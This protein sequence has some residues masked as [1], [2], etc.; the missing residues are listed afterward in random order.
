M[1]LDT[2]K[3][4]QELLERFEIKG[5]N[6]PYW[7]ADIVRD[8]GLNNHVV[9][10]LCTEMNNEGFVSKTNQEASLTPEGHVF[11]H[12]G[13]YERHLVENIPTTQSVTTTPNKKD[14]TH[15]PIWYASTIFKYFVWPLLV[16]VLGA[17]ILKLLNV[18]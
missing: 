6:V 18:V 8:T 14:E 16:L 11:F 7:F 5:V 15:K 2:A 3:A 9:N 4:K 10:A 17:I 13:G 12:A 1:N